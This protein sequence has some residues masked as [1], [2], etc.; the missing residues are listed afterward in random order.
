MKKVI[1]ILLIIAGV[2]LAAYFGIWWGLVDGII[3][4][5]RAC[6]NGVQ[7]GPL[8]WSIVRIMLCELWAA[9]AYL[10]VAGPGLF[11]LGG[12]ERGFDW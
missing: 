8:A 11:L 2:L 7:A 5:V 10:I 12:V 3:G 1:G 4:I 9:I 6:Q